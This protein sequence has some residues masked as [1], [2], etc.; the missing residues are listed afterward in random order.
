MRRLTESVKQLFVGCRNTLK[1][2]IQLEDYEEEGV[3]TFAALK[4]AFQTLE[5]DVSEELLD[6]ILFIMY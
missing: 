1:E 5:I 6:Y 3:V 2:T 4:D